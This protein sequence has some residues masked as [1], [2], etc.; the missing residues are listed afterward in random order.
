MT[1]KALAFFTIIFSLF[2]T[3]VIA[4]QFD[5]K[6]GLW[7]TQYSM[8]LE[9]VPPQIAAMMQQATPRSETEC[10]KDSTFDFVP[11]DMG[12]NCTYNK[13]NINANKLTFSFVCKDHGITATG[14]GGV[15]YQSS[16]VSGWVDVK[17]NGPHGGPMRMRH[18][19][20]GKRVGPCA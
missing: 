4:E 2:C 8:K 5:I 10:V 1:R 3:T 16:S 14:K 18:S 20:K 13:S 11:K 7:K 19:F 6:P 9:G 17:T 12:D 15:D